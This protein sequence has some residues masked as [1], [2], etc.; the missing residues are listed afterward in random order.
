MDFIFEQMLGHLITTLLLL[1][2]SK[3]TASYLALTGNCTTGDAHAIGYGDS[4]IY[5]S[6]LGL[7]KSLQ[8]CILRE[9]KIRQRWKTINAGEWDCSSADWWVTYAKSSRAFVN[10]EKKGTQCDIWQVLF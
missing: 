7:S 5:G 9:T 1:V 10:V 4:R 8:T 3:A 2:T 6:R